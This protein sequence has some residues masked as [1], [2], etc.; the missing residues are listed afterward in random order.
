MAAFA[1]GAL[2][3][4]GVGVVAGTLAASNADE[5]E[6]LRVKAARLARERDRAAAQRDRLRA[7]RDSLETRL[8]AEPTAAVCPL[9]SVRTSDTNLTPL[10]SVAY[11]CGWHVLWE[12]V[13]R[14]GE[15]S[16]EQG[17]PGLLVDFLFLSRLPIDR[18]PGS[19][20]SADIEV[21]DWHDDPGDEADALPAFEEWI[22]EERRAFTKPPGER[23]LET[24]A[25]QRALLLAGTI[26]S[27]DK[28]V[29]ARVYLWE[30]IDEAARV[31]HIMRAFTLDPSP[32][33]RRVHQ[34]VVRSFRVIER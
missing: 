7:E 20:S 12:P 17:R 11:P 16:S 26:S 10:Y 13:R 30:Y 1:A 18:T 25:G 3:L 33:V 32:Q 4:T 9:P 6:A 15:G 2:A 31:R 8:A 28:P 14:T 5:L 19:G 21:A 29:P 34:D 22:A 27:P 23:F 24:A